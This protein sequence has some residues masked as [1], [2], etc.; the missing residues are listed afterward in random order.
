MTGVSNKLKYRV[1]VAYTDGSVEK[2]KVYPKKGLLVFSSGK[3]RKGKEVGEIAFL[4]QSGDKLVSTPSFPFRDLFKLEDGTERDG[5]IEVEIL[6]EEYFD[7]NWQFDYEK[8][9]QRQDL[10]NQVKGLPELGHAERE[11][12]SRELARVEDPGHSQC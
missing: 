11:I 6:I 12:L 4:Q 9:K 7:P 1:L 2:E 10:L 5:P 3:N 8:F